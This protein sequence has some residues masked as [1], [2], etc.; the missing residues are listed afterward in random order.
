L[1]CAVL[2]YELYLVFPEEV[3]ILTQWYFEVKQPVKSKCQ[4]MAFY[5]IKLFRANNSLRP[6]GYIRFHEV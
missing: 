1:I 5:R 6:T 3:C 2:V 4:W